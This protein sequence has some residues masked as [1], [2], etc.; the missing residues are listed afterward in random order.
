MKFFD[1]PVFWIGFFILLNAILIIFSPLLPFVDLPNHLA[2]A[3]IYRYYGAPGNSFTTYYQLVPWYFPNQ[4]H[5]WFC[6]LEIFPTVEIGNKAFYILYIA[7]LPISIYLIVKALGGNKWI[8]LLSFTLVY[9]YNVTYGF[10]GY[11]ISIPI[12]FL[13]FYF[14]IIDFKRSALLLKSI[15]A[16]LLILLFTMHAQVALFGG[17]I[18]G[19]CSL[20]RYRKSFKGLALAFATT[21]PLILLVV[22]WWVLKESTPEQSTLEY[23]VNYYS[24]T[25]FRN[26]AE[27]LGLVAYENFQLRE[28]IAGILLALFLTLLLVLPVFVGWRKFWRNALQNFLKEGNIYITIFLIIT[29]GCYFFLPNEL[30]GQS[31]ISQR[32]NIFFWLVLIIFISLYLPELNRKFIGIYVVATLTVYSILWGEYFIAF[33]RENQ[34]FN[35]E[36]FANVDN[37]QKMSGLIFDYSFRGRRVY[38]HFQNYFI[39][40]QKGISSSKIIDYRFGV[41]NRK[42]DTA[43]LPEHYDW[44]PQQKGFLDSLPYKKVDLLLVKGDYPTKENHVDAFS[45][46]SQK[47]PWQLFKNGEDH[48]SSPEVFLQEEMKPGNID[49]EQRTSEYSE[50]N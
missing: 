34:D 49:K 11:T 30:P 40:W 28:G 29:F 6:S 7:L 4:F 2:E 39:T 45:L 43:V 24:S 1:K 47:G 8:S 35:E 50:K 38:I 25:Y 10:S 3:T 12:V 42:V 13:L 44:S 36:Y 31:P 21:I 26:F 32:F 22:N 15:I 17:L 23:L 27:R 9:G 5:I 37:D 19:F 14:I 41:I 46:V 16:L 18:Y 48:I 20:Y 33:N